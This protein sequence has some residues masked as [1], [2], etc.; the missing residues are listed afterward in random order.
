MLVPDWEHIKA[1]QGAAVSTLVEATTGS[2]VGAE[3]ASPC[4]PRVPFEKSRVH[5]LLTEV[6]PAM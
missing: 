1:P 6:L 4:L 2:G 3:R 5:L